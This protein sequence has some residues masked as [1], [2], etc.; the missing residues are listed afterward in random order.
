[1]VTYRSFAVSC[2]APVFVGMLVA[3]CLA[4]QQ[5]G[6]AVPRVDSQ[7]AGA[8][9]PIR[10][11][12][13]DTD[14]DGV[15]TRAE[16]RG[17]DDA[18]RQ[19]DVNHDGVLSGKEVAP[20]PASQLSVRQRDELV[21]QFTRADRD[22]DRRLRRNEWTLDLGSFEQVDVNGDGMV[23]RGEF[24][25][26]RPS[27]AAAGADSSAGSIADL[28]RGTPA[29]QTGFDRGLTDGRQAGKEDRNVNGGKWDLE[30]QRELEQA[31]AGYQASLGA[32]V[33]YQAGYRTGFRRGYAEGFGPR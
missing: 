7:R 4:A 1:M 20:G 30:G 25:N 13:M 31:D 27:Q 21:A 16:W 19:Q 24:L 18:F 5:T 28:R 6:R 33:D 12:S 23:T 22:G 17:S 15:I 11:Q 26:A 14:H 10:F 29:F 8:A 2:L 3:P 32:R 9:A